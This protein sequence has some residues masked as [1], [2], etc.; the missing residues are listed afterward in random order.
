MPGRL[1]IGGRSAHKN[2][3]LICEELFI[4]LADVLASGEPVLKTAQFHTQHRC[5]ESIQAGV[6]SHSDMLGMGLSAVIYE[7]ADTAG[8]L[9]ISR[10]DGT[11]V[12]ESTQILG[13]VKGE[14]GYIAE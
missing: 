6:A 10:C 13:G 7:E 12:P 4:E 8:Y 2:T 1:N 3:V 5:L 14:A 11:R 9:G